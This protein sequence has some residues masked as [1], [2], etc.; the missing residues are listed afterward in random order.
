MAFSRVL[1]ALFLATIS[2]STI[3]SADSAQN[4]R[5]FCSSTPYNSEVCLQALEP[6]P[7]VSP[8]GSARANFI[9]YGATVTNFYVKDKV[10]RWF[11]QSCPFYS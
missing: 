4:V 9:R 1:L 11:Y 3:S 2:S 8:D 10:R 7:L 5:I 6:V